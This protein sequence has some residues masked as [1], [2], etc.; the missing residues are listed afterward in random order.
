MSEPKPFTGPIN[1]PRPLNESLGSANPLYMLPEDPLV[2][3][4]LI[5]ALQTPLSRTIIGAA[6]SFSAVGDGAHGELKG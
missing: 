3:E 1:G 4:A 6:S 5:P 2:P